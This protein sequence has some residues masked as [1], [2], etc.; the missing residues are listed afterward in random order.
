MFTGNILV[1][2]DQPVEARGSIEA[3]SHFAQRE[4]IA[5]AS[6][7]VQMMQALKEQEISLVFLDIDMPGAGGFAIAKY[8]EEKHP[9]LPYVFLTG[10]ASFAAESYDYEPLDFLIKPLDMVRLSK[11][12]DRLEAQRTKGQVISKVAVESD[13][14]L[15]LLDPAEVIYAVREG[16]KVVLHCLNGRKFAVNHSMDDLELML[17]EDGFFRNHQSYLIDLSKIVYMKPSPFGSSYEAVLQGGASVPVS[18]NKYGKLKELLHKK[19]V[20]F[21]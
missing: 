1:V 3:I 19:G 15:T 14:G 4:H 17:G 12:F 5:Y 7:T 16:R 18:R 10:Y 8:L 11:T 20:R 13:Q 6:D 9:G 21:M 2:D